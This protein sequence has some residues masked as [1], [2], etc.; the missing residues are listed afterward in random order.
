MKSSRGSPGEGIAAITKPAAARMALDRRL[1]KV[2]GGLKS[3][4]VV[5]IIAALTNTGCHPVE[6]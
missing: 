6:Y 5:I 4:A 3:G 2:V 1:T